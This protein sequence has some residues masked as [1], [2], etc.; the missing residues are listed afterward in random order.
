MAGTFVTLGNSTD[1]FPRLLDALRRL[2]LPPPV[3]VQSGVTAVAAP[4]GW[5]VHPFL[6]PAAYRAAMA[7]A[8]LV[9]CHGAA[10]SIWHARQAGLLPVVLCRRAR[11]GEIV[12]DHQQAFCRALAAEGAILLAEEAA[13]LGAA[14]EAALARQAAGDVPPPA[15]HAQGLID[16]VALAIRDEATRL[17]RRP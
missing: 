14:I 9:V 15:P 1:P 6:D 13:D 17:G 3:I 10:G 4:E 7:E 11:L 2:A 16:A 8:R 5:R 12:D